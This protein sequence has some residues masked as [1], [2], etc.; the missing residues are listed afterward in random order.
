MGALCIRRCPR[1]LQDMVLPAR[2]YINGAAFTEGIGFDGSSVRGFKSIE[3][4]DMIFMPDAK[5]LSIMPWVTDE[6]QKSAIILGDALEAFGGKRTSVL[7]K[8]LCGKKSYKSSKRHGI[9]WIFAPELEHFVFTSID[10]T[11]LTWDLWAAP[12]GGEGDAWGAPRVVP[13][14]PRNYSRRIYP[15]PKEAYY[16]TPPEDTTVAYRNEVAK[17]WK[18]TLA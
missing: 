15:R 3:E 10:P 17:F 2:E 6:A 13:E 5:T 1:N 4:S 11:K 8:R 16:R 18:T 12:K 7:P 9:H 14:L